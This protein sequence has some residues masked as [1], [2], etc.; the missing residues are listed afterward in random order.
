MTSSFFLEVLIVSDCDLIYKRDAESGFQILWLVL[1]SV[2]LFLLPFFLFSFSRSSPPCSLLLALR[3]FVP[4]L[5]L[6]PNW[7]SLVHR[8]PRPRPAPQPAPLWA[9]ALS[10]LSLS[11]HLCF[12]LISISWFYVCVSIKMAGMPAVSH[13]RVSEEKNLQQFKKFQI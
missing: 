4:L 10:R 13:H 8:A 5:R 6:K 1:S 12:P 7:S 11:P 3:R 2:M 9:S